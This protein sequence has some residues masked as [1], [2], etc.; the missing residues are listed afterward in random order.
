MSPGLIMETPGNLQHHTASLQKAQHIL[1]Q[2]KQFLCAGCKRD[3]P[4]RLT[5]FGNAP[6]SCRRD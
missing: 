6:E 3:C 4:R 2:A 5:P 1:H